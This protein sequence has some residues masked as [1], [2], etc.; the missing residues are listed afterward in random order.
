M[1][2]S[3]L[4]LLTSSA[5]PE[6]LDEFDG[7]LAKAWSANSH[8]PEAIRIQVGIAVGEIGANIIRYAAVTGPVNIRMHVRPMASEV[9]VEFVDDGIPAQIDLDNVSLPEDMA[10]T[11]RGL[12]LA[13][14]ALAQLSYRRDYTE[15]HWILVS[16]HFG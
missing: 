11:G 8:V 3:E 12:A 16:K 9:Q 1:T 14:A 10:E 6:A 2:L 13:Q 4:Q 15:N 7:L 5:K